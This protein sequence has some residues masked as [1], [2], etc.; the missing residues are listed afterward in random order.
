MFR[1]MIFFHDITH[2]SAKQAIFIILENEDTK[3][4]AMWRKINSVACIGTLMSVIM[5]MF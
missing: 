5:Q 3:Q 1:M 2:A 4:E